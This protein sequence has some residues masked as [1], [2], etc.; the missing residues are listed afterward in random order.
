MNL[1]FLTSL[2]LPL[3]AL[4]ALAGFAQDKPAVDPKVAEAN[5]AIISAEKPC[6]PLKTCPVSGEALGKTAVDTVVDG[7][8]VRVCCDNCVAPAAKDGAA[9]RAKVEAAAI[10]QQKKD[11]P[12]DTCVIS[13]EKLTP[14][15][16]DTVVGTRLVRV[17]CKKCAAAVAKDQAPTMKKLDEAYIAA[18]KDKYPLK[19]C[20]VTDEEIGASK[21]MEPVDYLYGNRYFRLC[22]G[23]CK[24]AVAKDPAGMWAKVEAARA[25]KK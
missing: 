17:C 21:D 13:G 20:V 19:T 18:Q 22:C 25:A 9:I 11:Y 24:K 23:G 2:T 8:L 1:S 15:S 3:V 16:V 14:E 4:A 5:K 12:L 6:Y 7:H 10:E